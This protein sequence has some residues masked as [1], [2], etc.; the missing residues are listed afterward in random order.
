LAAFYTIGVF[1]EE[2]WRARAKLRELT[3]DNEGEKEKI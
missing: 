2:F 3:N 1:I